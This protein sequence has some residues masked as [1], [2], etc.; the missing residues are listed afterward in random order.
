MNNIYD[1]LRMLNEKLNNL[2]ELS[3]KSSD[4]EDRMKDVIELLHNKYKLEK[5]ITELSLMFKKV[6]ELEQMFKE[7]SDK[8]IENFIKEDNDE[9]QNTE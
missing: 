3:Q 2:I 7:L 6:T 1:K 9:E 5:D 4:E 8:Y